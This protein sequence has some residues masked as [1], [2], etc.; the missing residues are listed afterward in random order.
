MGVEAVLRPGLHIEFQAAVNTR[1][2]DGLRFL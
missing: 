2:M 1:K